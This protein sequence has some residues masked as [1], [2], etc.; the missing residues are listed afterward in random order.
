MNYSFP[1]NYR[2]L[3]TKPLTRR[4]YRE[5]QEFL[6]IKPLKDLP[7]SNLTLQ[8]NC[9]DSTVHIYTIA[10][11]DLVKGRDITVDI[12]FGNQNYDSLVPGK[13]ISSIEIKLDR[14]DEKLVLIPTSID[15]DSWRFF[16]YFN[17]E[18]G[19]DSFVSTGDK[20]DMISISSITSH[21]HLK[22]GYSLAD[23]EYSAIN[24]FAQRPFNVFSGFKPVGEIEAT[25][26]MFLVN[27]VYELLDI[28]GNME[29]VRL[30]VEDTNHTYPTDSENRKAIS[31]R[32]RYSY[33]EKAL[34]RV[35]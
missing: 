1:G 28:N 18:G 33:D 19:M 4:I 25:K 22:P 15:T 23:G 29:L 26:D 10:L 30:I 32:A 2:F 34:D 21:H 17:S 31:F 20:Q 16:F 35:S 24:N 7:T 11:G 6:Y 13:T 5:Q 3:T 27:E 12:G 8:I 14:D 9:S